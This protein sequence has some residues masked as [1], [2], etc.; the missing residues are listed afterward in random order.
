MGRPPWSHPGWA[1]PKVE[2]PRTDEQEIENMTPKPVL[3]ERNNGLQLHLLNCSLVKL[4]GER[5]FLSWGPN[6]F[7]LSFCSGYL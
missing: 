5:N 6:T 3:Q 2:E 7:L 1:N 4:K